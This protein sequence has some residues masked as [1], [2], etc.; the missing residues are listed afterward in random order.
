MFAD[1]TNLFSNSSSYE[2]LYAVTNTQLKR[3]E[4]WLS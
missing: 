1:D 3:V 4:A 2:A